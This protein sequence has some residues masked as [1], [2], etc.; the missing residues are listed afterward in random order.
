MFQLLSG[1]TDAELNKMKLKRDVNKYFYIKQG[2]TP[3]VDSIS[4]KSD[5]KT[6]QSAFKILGFTPDNIDAIWRTVSAILHLVSNGFV[7]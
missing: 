1:A 5:Y 6:V 2:G 4:D 7:I 3:R